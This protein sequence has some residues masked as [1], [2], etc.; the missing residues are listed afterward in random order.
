M[1]ADKEIGHIKKD[2]G[3]SIMPAVVGCQAEDR[4]NSEEIKPVI[5]TNSRVMLGWRHQFGV[6]W[7]A[8]SDLILSNQYSSVG[9]T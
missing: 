5:L 4:L 3:M 1:V 2:K 8:F 6:T 7:K 9:E